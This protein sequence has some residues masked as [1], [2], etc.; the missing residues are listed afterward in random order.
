MSDP[1][2]DD[3]DQEGVPSAS[4]YPMLEWEDAEHRVALPP[5]LRMAVGV[6]EPVLRWARQKRSLVL[7]QHAVDASII[8][9]ISRHIENWTYCGPE[10]GNTGVWRV[11]FAVEARWYSL[12]LG[13][14][15]TGSL[16]VVTIFGSS[17]ASF[18]R[19]RL[20]GM[21]IVVEQ[22]RMTSGQGGGP[23]VS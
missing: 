15:A 6:D 1:A 11:L 19:N 5:S 20:R 3:T 7:A 18:L 13:R 17:S 9:D 2:P 21:E 22:R 8:Q 14:D 16:N 10:R 12:T 4:D 23:G